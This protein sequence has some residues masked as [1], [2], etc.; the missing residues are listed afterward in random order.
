M[1]KI[2]T[3]FF[4]VLII[5]ACSIVVSASEEGK[6]NTAGDLYEAWCDNLPDYICGVWSEDG[7]T[8]NL[9]FGIQNNEI[10]RAGKEEML[11][12]VKNDSTLT[13]V[14]QEFSRNYLLQIQR[15]IDKYLSEDI[16]LISTALNDRYNRIDL[17]VLKEK[18]NDEETQR[19]IKEITDKYG[20]AVNLIYDDYAYIVTTGLNEKLKTLYFMFF[21]VCLVA[22]GSV[23]L[24]LQRR[25]AMLLQTTNGT[26]V[27]VDN[28]PSAKEVED[29]IRK[30]K[31]DIPT[32]LDN[33]IMSEIDKR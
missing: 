18:E 31:Y 32:D 21:A 19:A 28:A 33:K 22:V 1:K 6:Y 14:Y 23:F 27:A 24:M 17:G 13:F 12:L 5:C 25:K 16:G 11:R 20:I 2:I 15:E 9:T 10:G 8:T 4:A 26:T 29:M 30:S 7:G 3:M